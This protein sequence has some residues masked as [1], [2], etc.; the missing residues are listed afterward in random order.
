MILAFQPSSI[1]ELGRRGPTFGIDFAARQEL[2]AGWGPKS[3]ERLLLGP[4]KWTRMICR[5]LGSLH[6]RIYIAQVHNTLT[7]HY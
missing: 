3:S 7:L 6:L 4:S 1:A 2:F 5:S